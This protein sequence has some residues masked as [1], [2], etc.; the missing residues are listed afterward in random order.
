MTHLHSLIVDQPMHPL[1]RA[2][3]W[4]E[5]LLRHPNLEDQFRSSSEDVLGWQYFWSIVPLLVVIIIIIF[6][7]INYCINIFCSNIQKNCKS[8]KE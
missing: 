8:K 4:M 2:V 5:Y 7:I 3:W 1:D 6:I